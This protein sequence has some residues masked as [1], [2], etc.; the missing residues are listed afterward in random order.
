MGPSGSATLEVTVSLLAQSPRC[1]AGLP[2]LSFREMSEAH[3]G[4]VTWPRPPSVRVKAISHLNVSTVFSSFSC[5]DEQRK[6]LVK[7]EAKNGGKT[8]GK[9]ETGK[10]QGVLKEHFIRS[11]KVTLSHGFSQ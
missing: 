9:A 5:L 6:E 7:H 2:I 1:P 8:K 4:Y 3:G 11:L 10:E